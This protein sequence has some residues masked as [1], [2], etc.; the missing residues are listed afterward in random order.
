[1]SP[2]AFTLI[3]TVL[4]ASCGKAGDGPSG[5]GG[6]GGG[7]NPKGSVA[8]ESWVSPAGTDGTDGGS[9]TDIYAG[10]ME[11]VFTDPSN[12]YLNFVDRDSVAFYSY[13]QASYPT[14]EIFA[15]SSPSTRLL[16]ARLSGD[17][18]RLYRVDGGS[19]L[20]CKKFARKRQLGL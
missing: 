17:T 13:D 1:M 8:G 10:G 4:L 16:T 6:D 15:S 9:G 11:L 5:P 3:V 12:C 20:F 14:V 18:L 19:E 7:D 2:R